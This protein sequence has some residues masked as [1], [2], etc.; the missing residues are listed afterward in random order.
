MSRVAAPPG[1]VLWAALALVLAERIAEILINRRNSARL[2]EIG[3]VWLRRDGFGLIL[4]AQVVLFAG[5]ILEGRL[6]PWTGPHAWTSP[7][8][9]V[10]LLA[11]VARY[12][13]IATLGWRWSIRVVTIP[14]AP[15]IERGPYRFLRHPNY[16]VVAAEALVLPLAF[17]AWAT[18]LV[19]LPLQLVALARRIRIE[20]RALDGASGEHARTPG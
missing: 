19:A 1:W 2:Q 11:Q 17:G 15:R 12:W 5:L 7:L 20:D 9:G 3:A 18:L 16:V 6:A 14:G 4:L 13:V 8:L 10:A